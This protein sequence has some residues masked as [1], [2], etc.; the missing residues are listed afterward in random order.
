M[1]RRRMLLAAAAAALAM[2]AAWAQEA[3]APP[4]APAPAPSA[5]APAAACCTVAKMTPVE[6]ELVDAVGSKRS[7]NGDSFAIRLAAPLVVDGR[8]LA[9]AGTT[10]MGEVVHA[11]KARA[12]GKAGELILAAR[13]LD[14]GGTR[15]PLRSFRYGPAQGKD[16]S[17]AV[18]VG[19]MVASAVLPVASV[20]GFLVSGGEIEI[21]AGTRASAKVAAD[22]MLAP[23]E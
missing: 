19:N 18:G 5:D 20:L 1:K 8:T 22:T 9:P 17:G 6:I 7:R 10:G 23:A 13:Y 21:P 11:A 12:A 3:A 15:L 14:I 2:P 16:N 4:A